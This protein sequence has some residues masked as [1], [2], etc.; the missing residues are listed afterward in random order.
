MGL[1]EVEIG[2]ALEKLN[3][4]STT[5]AWNNESAHEINSGKTGNNESMSK[6]SIKA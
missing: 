2:E 6:V 5:Q 1:V 3:D 4:V